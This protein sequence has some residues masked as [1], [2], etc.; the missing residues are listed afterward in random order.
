MP[1][2]RLLL[3]L[4]LGLSFGTACKRKTATVEP[5][6][7]GASM[8]S[9]NEWLTL[10]PLVEAA[11]GTAPAPTVAALERASA[12]LRDGKAKSADAALAE[13]ADTEGRHWISVAR[14]DLAAIYFTVCIRGVAWRLADLD[15]KTQPTRR[16]DY[17]EDIKLGSGDVAVEAMLNNVEAAVVAKDPT[18][19][20]QAR[21]ARAR[22]TAY[23]ARCP[24]NKDVGDMAAGVLKGDLA[25]LAAESHLTPDLAF[26]WAG[27]QMTEFSGAAA[28]PFLLQAREGGYDDPAISTMLAVIALEQ[29]DLA[30]ADKHAQEAEATYKK[31]GDVPQQAQALFIR[32]EAARAKGDTKTARAHYEAARKLDP[33]HAPALF[34]ITRI[35][36]KESGTSAAIRTL[37][38]AFPQILLTGPLVGNAL[39]DAIDNMESFV[40]LPGEAEL[41]TVSR[42]ALLADVEAEPDLMRRGLRYFFAATLDARLGEYDH[43]RSHAI[44]ARDEWRDQGLPPPV[45]IDAFL[46][47]LDRV[48]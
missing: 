46:D 37:Q 34:G 23:V 1:V 30:V 28:K 11:R 5:G 2:R 36:L 40:T 3:A 25:T 31:L 42:D 13:V 10:A 15:P 14:A 8:G 22:A 24:A 48:R 12:L 7:A 4:V 33:A 41:I 9:W 43:A 39:T 35:V 20:T 18:L 6:G 27:V 26:M 32:G 16:S 21:I 17:S 19:Q 38:A 29:R 44:L 45:D 47:R